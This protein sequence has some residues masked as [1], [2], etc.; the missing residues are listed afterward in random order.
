M[1]VTIEIELPDGQE[2]PKAADIAMLTSP[3][4]VSDWWHISD[5]EEC[6]WDGA[7]LTNDDCREVLRR[8]GKYK[9]ANEG[10]NWEVL[11][12]HVDSFLREKA[13]S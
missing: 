13:K 10:I 2:V 7:D 4:W 11:Q 1:K 12:S 3:D 9:D 5:V 8:V 6:D